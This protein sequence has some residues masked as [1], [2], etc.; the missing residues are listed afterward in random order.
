M[1]ALHRQSPPELQP[2]GTGPRPCRQLHNCDGF[3][4]THTSRFEGVACRVVRAWDAAG[5]AY[6]LPHLMAKA[7]DNMTRKRKDARDYKRHNTPSFL[8]CC[9]QDVVCD[10]IRGDGHAVAKPAAADWGRFAD[11][12]HHTNV[13]TSTT[14]WPLVVAVLE[15]LLEVR[16]TLCVYVSG[17][18]SAEAA[19]L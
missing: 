16:G 3:V 19:Q 10:M 13:R 12:G 15:C 2:Q 4:D 6:T 1:P 8:A 7:N 14:C 11:V 17:P 5:M 9:V 18:I